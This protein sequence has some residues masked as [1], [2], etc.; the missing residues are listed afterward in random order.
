VTPIDEA[1]ALVRLDADIVHANLPMARWMKPLDAP[2]PPSRTR[3]AS[4]MK[5]MKRLVDVFEPALSPDELAEARRLVAAI[6]PN[7]GELD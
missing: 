2:K 5:I 6:D 1:S 7:R 3:I 4:L